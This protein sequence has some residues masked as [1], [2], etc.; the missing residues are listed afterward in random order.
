ML[1]LAVDTSCDAVSVCLYDSVAKRILSESSEAMLRG[2]VE[3]LAP[4]V[5]QALSNAKRDASDLQRVAVTVGP[6]SFTGIRVGL[7]FC[8]AIGL[9]LDIPVVGISTLV[10]LAGPLCLDQR[11]GVIVSAIDARH[12]SLYFQFFE[13]NGRPLSPARVDSGG[14]AV[15]AAGIGPFRLT[16]PGAKLFAAE[17]LQAGLQFDES[18]AVARPDIVN[19]AR[20]GVVSDP[21]LCLARP[22]YIKPPDARISRI[23]AIAR[24]SF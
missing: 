17:A 19:L 15:R 5:Q 3:V 21:Q 24:G 10:A 6:G 2:H 20:L 8:F 4:L 18:G 16:G 13:A 9:A 7:A 14:A 22:I 12:G 23:D 11:P 1:I